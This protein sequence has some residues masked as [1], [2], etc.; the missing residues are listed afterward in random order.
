[1]QGEEVAGAVNG[2]DFEQP[3]DIEQATANDISAARFQLF[4]NDKKALKANEV[5][6]ANSGETIFC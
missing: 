4:A 2:L 3:A 6:K 5:S 1:M